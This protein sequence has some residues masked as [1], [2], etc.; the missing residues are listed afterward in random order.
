MYRTLCPKECPVFSS[1]HGT[2][3]LAIKEVSTSFKEL[4]PLRVHSLTTEN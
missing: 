2:F 3:M 4:K 1:V